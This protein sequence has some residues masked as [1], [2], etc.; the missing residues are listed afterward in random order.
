[1]TLQRTFLKNFHSA[2]IRYFAGEGVIPS[3]PGLRAGMN[4]A[5]TKNTVV[6]GRF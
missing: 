6:S 4:P 3:Q 5:P 2:E 1:M